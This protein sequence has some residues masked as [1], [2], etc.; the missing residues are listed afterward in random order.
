MKKVHL[1][2]LASALYLLSGCG[3]TKPSAQAGTP[4]T[5]VPDWF[6]N[7]PSDGKMLYGTGTQQSKSL[8]LA[9]DQADFSGCREVAKAL[10]QKVEGLTKSNLGQAGLVGSSEV[11]EALSETARSIVNTQLT[12]CVNK[13]REVR[14]MPD[15][16]YKIYSLMTLDNAAALATFKQAREAQ[17]ALAQSKANFEELDKLLAR[18][19]ESGAK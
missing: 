8:Q 3:G 4:V 16:S 18:E 1:S 9:K 14:E 13:K 15:G 17:Q 2:L 5:G 11:N 12:G 7:Q 6:I 10:G 19:L